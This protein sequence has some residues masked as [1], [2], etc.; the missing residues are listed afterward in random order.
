MNHR[1]SSTT[2]DTNPATDSSRSTDAE[3]TRVILALIAAVVSISFAAIFFRKAETP[4]VLAAGVR[5]GIA[6][7]LLF[8]FTV[9]AFS[10]SVGLL[11]LLGAG[12][13]YALHFGAWVASLER[14]SVAAS[15]TLV[16]VTPLLL[17]LVGYLTG[18]DAPSGRQWL[19]LGVAAAGVSLLGWSGSHDGSLIGN[20]L[21]ILGAAAMAAYLFIGRRLAPSGIEPLALTG[22]AATTG[23]VALLSSAWALGYGISD[24]PSQGWLFLS[25]SALVP[26]LIGHTMLTWS[27]RHT[28]PTTVG[29]ATLGEPV[30]STLLAWLWLS[31]LPTT[32]TLVG[33]VITASA[34]GIS[35]WP[36]RARRA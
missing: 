24:V 21:A 2:A 15:V 8:P 27:L 7:L 9:R 23:A 22:A 20:G 12:A 28:S 31:E 5:L 26:Q 34:V 25:L 33:C 16:T 17:G 19:A 6:A 4:A 10:R 32:I 3:R 36:I 11:W 29:L 1:P 30:G 35:L 14:T 18:R 13:A